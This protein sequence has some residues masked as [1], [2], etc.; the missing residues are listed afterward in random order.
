M[1]ILLL[2]ICMS[3]SQAQQAT[4]R[5][6]PASYTVPNVDLA[7]SV[8]VTV[9]D[10]ENLYGYEFKLYYS[11]DILNGSSVTEGPFLKTGGISTFFYLAAFNDNY[12]A[13]HGLANVLCLRTAANATGVN[14]TGTLATINFRST[15]AN[16][17]RILHMEDVKLSDS[18]S[19]A[20]P[21]TVLDGEVTVLPEFPTFLMLPLF[22]ALSIIIVALITKIKP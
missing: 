10:V 13:T 2:S 19:T 4:V 8:N 5:V 12:N 20:I 11:N 9:E 15:S 3:Q 16:G 18:N 7:F 21:D 17:P 14:G 22:M 1:T 6:V